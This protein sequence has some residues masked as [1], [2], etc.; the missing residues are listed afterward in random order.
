MKG[1]HLLPISWCCPEIYSHIHV[2]CFWLGIYMW[3]AHHKIKLCLSLTSCARDSNLLVVTVTKGYA[4]CVSCFSKSSFA[5]QYYHSGCKNAGWNCSLLVYIEC[6]EKKQICIEW[7]MQLKKKKQRILQE[8]WL[9]AWL[10]FP[11][12]R[13]WTWPS[14]PNY[15]LVD[16]EVMFSCPIPSY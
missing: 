5:T 4:Q 8:A 15:A 9:G 11:L 10:K 14:N 3:P 16:V 13:K 1:I 6:H 2:N 12:W 7:C